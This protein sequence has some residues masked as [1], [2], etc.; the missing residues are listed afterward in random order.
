MSP[1]R[2]DLRISLGIRYVLN[3]TQNVNST[4]NNYI[5]IYV[6]LLLLV[7]HHLRQGNFR[8]VWHSLQIQNGFNRNPEHGAEE[9]PEDYAM[10]FVTLVGLKGKGTKH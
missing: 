5:Y 2:T 3:R 7:W 9:L 8:T 10:N 1:G 6:Y 4:A